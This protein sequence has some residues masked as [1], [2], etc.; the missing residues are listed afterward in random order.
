MDLGLAEYLVWGCLISGPIALFGGGLLYL[1]LHARIREAEGRIEGAAGRSDGYIRRHE[2][3]LDAISSL[4]EREVE[5]LRK[6][7]DRM[8]A[9]E[10][11]LPA[12]DDRGRFVP[13]AGKTEGRIA[14]ALTA[15][16]TTQPG[17]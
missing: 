15:I 11:R 9:L 14:A 12:R 3:W 4:R 13:H 5:D 6:L 17:A 7:R 16:T 2:S 1:R 10:A 8:A